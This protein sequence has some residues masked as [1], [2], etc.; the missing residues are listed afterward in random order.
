M[1]FLGIAAILIIA[2]II[3]IFCYFKELPKNIS[4]LKKSR[5]EYQKHLDL[6]VLGKFKVKTSEDAKEEDC[7]IEYKS[8]LTVIILF[9]VIT[10][11]TIVYLVYSLTELANGVVRIFQ[12]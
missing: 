9:S 4:E 8:N 5:R 10:T 7:R 12:K 11:V 6:S 3:W 1:S 2:S